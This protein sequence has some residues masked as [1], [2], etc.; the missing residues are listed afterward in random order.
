MRRAVVAA[1]LGLC[2]AAPAGAAA[3]SVEV[4]SPDGTIGRVDLP[5][6]STRAVPAAE[7]RALASSPI[8]ALQNA[9]SPKNH[10]DLV[11]MGDGYTASE[12]ALFRQHALTKWQRIATTEPFREYA[13]YF[14]VWLVD[15]E[16]NESGVDNDPTPPTM[17]DTALDGQFWCQG[18][19]RLLCVDQAKATAAAKAAPGADQILVL[20][21]STK[22]RRGRRRRG[23]VVG[24][25]RGGLADHGPR[26]RPLAG[27]PGR[28]VRLLLPRGRGRGLDPGRHDPGAL[29]LVSG[30]RSGRAG[31]A[32]HHGEQGP[33]R[34]QG[35]VV[36]LGRR[37]VA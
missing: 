28:R 12:Q 8:T 22:Y 30:R 10:I 13:S 17:R 4:F 24:R 15:V 32:E 35:E 33:R 25:Q 3:R 23:H 9:G 20:A 14:N 31:R 11:I 16:S 6:R 5:V 18:T 21:N 27:R 37:A 36:A 34:R 26:A 19:E 2:V 1:L 29:R 7:A